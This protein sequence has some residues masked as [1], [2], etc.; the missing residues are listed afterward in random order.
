MPIW[1][2]PISVERFDDP[3]RPSCVWRITMAILSPR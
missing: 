2:K 3:G 1:Q